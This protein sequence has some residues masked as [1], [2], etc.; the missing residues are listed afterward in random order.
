M[1]PVIKDF[2]ALPITKISNPKLT[3]PLG[4]TTSPHTRTRLYNLTPGFGFRICIY[5]R[6]TRMYGANDSR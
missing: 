2:Q 4:T 6:E 5:W 3:I 1:N